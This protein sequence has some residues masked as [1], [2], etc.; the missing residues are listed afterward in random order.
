MRA[1]LGLH[2]AVAMAPSELHW[3]TRLYPAHRRA[4]SGPAW[5]RFIDLFVDW[6]PT[7]D[8]GV[9]R[10]LLLSHLRSLPPGAFARVF[11]AT[12]G[13][14]AARLHRPRWAEKT[15]QLEL[16]T[17]E[18]RKGFP[19][20]YFVYLVR[21][22]RDVVVSTS[23]FRSAFA[24]RRLTRDVGWV[25]LNWR[26]SVRCAIRQADS[27]DRFLVV[28]YEELVSRPGETVAA[29]CGRLGLDFEPAMLDP[30]RFTGFAESKARSGFDPPAQIDGT[31]I[32]RFRGRL[33]P[34][35]QWICERLLGRDMERLGYAPDLAR[36]GVGESALLPLELAVAAADG[37]VRRVDRFLRGRP[38]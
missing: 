20:A 30:D 31:A 13:A 5:T 8:L 22:P 25:A 26:E 36:L 35:K 21:D 2:S 33:S 11:G 10:E 17:A 1:I 24:R 4:V 34:R 37:A 28:R 23:A 32:G 14:F 18:I 29:L 19:D 3:W 6:G 38:R 12:M 7:R 9:P 15:P 16:F 27:D